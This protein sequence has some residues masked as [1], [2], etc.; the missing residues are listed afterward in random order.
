MSSHA[1]FTRLI[2]ILG[3]T[4]VSNGLLQAPPR[5]TLEVLTTHE[6]PRIP[7]TLD[8][9]SDRTKLGTLDIPSLGI[10]TINW[11]SRKGDV[12]EEIEEAIG[13]ALA[14]NLNFFDTA[15]RYGGSLSTLVGLGWGECERL[16]SNSV[17]RLDIPQDK[18][19]VIATKFTP[20]FWRDSAADVVD[21]CRSSASR[22]GVESIDLYQVHMPDIVQPLRT[23]GLDKQ[24]DEI[25]WDGLA[26]CYL[27]GLV[28]NIGVSNYGPTLLKRCAE[29]LGRRGVPI[30]SN[31]IN[32]SLLYRNQGA[33][34]TVDACAE[35]GIRTLAY[36]PLG[37]G[38]LTGKYSLSEN[39]EEK[40]QTDDSSRTSLEL[41]DIR[42]YARGGTAGIPARGITPLIMVLEELADKYSKSV[43][44]VSLNWII[45]K[46]AIP[47]PGA[48]TVPHIRDNIGALGWRL[49]EDD[50][51]LLEETADSLGFDFNGAGFKRSNSKFV[52]Y[53]SEY[54]SL[55]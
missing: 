40:R 22:L 43:A 41:K 8:V 50:V 19:P 33:Q 16:L 51:L 47:I 1:S 30:A 20:G 9:I 55:E 5:S 54:W 49:S 29:A 21:A 15:E 48:K 6:S 2:S 32:Y 17:R 35:M 42:A 45:C 52:G 25:F 34:A 46:G 14:S 10:G 53:G 27:Q 28:K 11:S 7:S 44:Q 23:F 31:Q 38:L 18:A 12:N 36:F 39:G 4:G 13:I 37:M 26:E 24:K 3:L